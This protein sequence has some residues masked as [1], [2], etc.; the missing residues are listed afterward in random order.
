MLIPMI[1]AQ[2][3]AFWILAPLAVGLALGMALSSKP[4]HSALC[5][6]GVMICLAMLYAALDAPFLFVTQIIIY[7][8][9]VMMLFLFT[10]MLIGV[11]TRESMA[12][13]VF[14]HR[15]ATIILVI[16]LA[17]ML[18]IAVGRG[19]VTGAAGLDAANSVNGG[20]VPGIA[21]LIFGRYFFA[22][23]ATAALL[24]TA[25]LAAMVLAHSERL[26]PAERQRGR[27]ARRIR[28]YADKGA[29][30]GPLPGS[31]V[32]ARHNSNDYPA[33]LPDGS[34]AEASVSPTLAARGVAIVESTG[35]STLSREAYRAM[36]SVR[37]E[38]HGQTPPALPGEPTAE[39][40]VP[41]TT[42]EASK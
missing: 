25:A 41:A 34:V 31:G 8:G 39:A 30:P 22:F 33:L 21:A 11:D 15:A 27:A 9:S 4:V 16:G 42:E 24:I 37:A 32:Y 7:T 29:H 5:L 3:V 36:T 18:G 35:L 13:V 2:A 19:V 17:L 10:M 1:T 40:G 28:E 14:G 20:N 26:T 12:D 38:L 6:A 23:E